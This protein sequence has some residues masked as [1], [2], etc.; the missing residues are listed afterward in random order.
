M[1]SLFASLDIGRKSLQSHQL[2]LQVTSNNMSNINTPGYSRQHAVFE[3]DFSVQTSAGLIGSGVTVKN[4]ASA[5]DQFIEL[6]VVEETQHASE[7]EAMFNTLD[8][9]QRILPSGSGGVQDGISQFFNSFSTLANNPESS[10]LR[11]AVLS[12]A[13]NLATSFN[14]AARQL[15]E[16]QSSV[17]RS[18][19]DA[20][21]KVNILAGNVATLNQE[22]IVAEGGGTEASGL[23]D[24]RQEYI[25]ELSSLVDVRYYEAQDGAFY[26]SVA[27]GHSLVSGNT[28]QPLSA[29]PVGI[30][31]HFE[32]RSGVNNITNLISGGEVAGFIEIR[33]QK[34]PTYLGDLDTLANTVINQVNTQHALGTDLL[35]NAGG[36]FFN[37]TPVPAA[38]LVLP[39]GA[40]RNFSVNAALVADPRLVAAGQSGEAGDNANALALAGLAAVKTLNGGTETF[41]EGFASLQFRVGTDTQGAKRTLDA[42]SAVLTQLQNQRDSVSGVSLDEEALDMVRFQRAYQAATKF[43]STIDQLTGDIIAAFGG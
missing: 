11:N 36:N 4:I 30:Q 37:P 43:I 39:A 32:V 33:D 10:A 15:E 2:A 3:A 5:R 1:G 27:G 25:K 7:Q 13:Q 20:V 9:I 21:N 24:Q 17:N 42:Q 29:V 18:I 19:E 34:I 38:P 41:A 26:V 22:I 8:Q 40:A 31:G 6:R 12:A 28:A 23:R 16:T 14:G 35:G